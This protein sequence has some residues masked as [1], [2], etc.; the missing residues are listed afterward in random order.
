MVQLLSDSLIHGVSSALLPEYPAE[1]TR[2]W[3]WAP[4]RT[5]INLFLPS[6]LAAPGADDDGSGTVTILEALR[7]LLQ[8]DAIAKGNASN[9]VEFHWY[10]A[11]EGGMLGSQAIFSN[12]KRNRR[13]IKAMLQQDMTGYVQGALNA[14]VE[15]AIGIMVDYVD[16]GL[17][18]FL[19]D[20]VT[21][22]SLSCPPRKAV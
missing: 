7:G 12:Y 2:L 21:A 1:R 17:T 3:C 9:T 22:V 13:E 15:E 14:G 19:K 20:V 6:I 10:S 8:S 5:R 11:E 16:Q 18:Q 4:I